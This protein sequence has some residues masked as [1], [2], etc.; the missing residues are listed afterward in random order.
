LSPGARAIVKPGRRPDGGAPH[1]R[2]ASRH[3]I[4]ARVVATARTRI[5][6]RQ[7]AAIIAVTCVLTP[8]FN[9]LTVQATMRSA[10]QGLLDGVIITV[11]VGG[12]LLFVRDGWWRRWFRSVGVRTDLVLNSAIVL[13]LFLVGRA[14]GQVVTTGDPRRFLGSFTD[15]HLAYALPFFALVAVTIQFV[16]ARGRLRRTRVF[17]GLTMPEPVISWPDPTG[18]A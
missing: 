16:R 15:A 13:A 6:L 7:L 14:A 2:G 17:C 3:A 12:Y 1:W 9:V 8:V 5:R 18:A 11:V 4:L 10:V